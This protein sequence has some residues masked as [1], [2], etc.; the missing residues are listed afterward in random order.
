MITILKKLHRKNYTVAVLLV[1]LAAVACKRVPDYVIQPDEMAEL[2]ADMHTAEA[3]VDNNYPDYPTDSAKML[4]KQSVLAKHGYT[5]AQ[6]DTSFMWYGAN[7]SKYS[8]V[9]EKT[10]AILEKRLTESGVAVTHSNGNTDS[11]DIWDMTRYVMVRP[12]SPS[13]MLTYRF[14]NDKEEWSKGD[15]FTLRAKFANTEGNSTVSMTANYDDGT[16]EVLTSR[17]SGD[18]WHEVSFF[19]DSMLDMKALSGSLSFRNERNTLIVD[20]IQFLRKPLDAALYSQ[21]YRQRQY[22]FADKR[23]KVPVPPNTEANTDS[24]TTNSDEKNVQSRSDSKETVK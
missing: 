12:T 19:A 2:M 4:L 16:F 5:L 3:V 21:R 10:V 1:I 6:L 7:L 17:F 11:V 20:S 14:D 22:N 8:E 15:M 23:Y 24:T 9:Y 18:G 13:R